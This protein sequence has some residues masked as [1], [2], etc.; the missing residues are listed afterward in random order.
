MQLRQYSRAPAAL[1]HRI[2]MGKGE[3][4]GFFFFF[5]PYKLKLYCAHIKPYGKGPHKP[6][7]NTTRVYSSPSKKPSINTFLLKP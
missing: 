6:K 7:G 5:L 3:T 4:L 2:E 1:K